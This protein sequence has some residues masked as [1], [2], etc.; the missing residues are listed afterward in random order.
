MISV[1]SFGEMYFLENSYDKMKK[2][3]ILTILRALL[4]EISGYAFKFW[5]YHVCGIFLSEDVPLAMVRKVSV[6]KHLK[7]ITNK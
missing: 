5:F 7:K 2:N 6:Q 3:Q 1:N 4:F